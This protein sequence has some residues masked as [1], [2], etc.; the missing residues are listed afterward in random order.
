[1]KQKLDVKQRY[2]IRN[3]QGLLLFAQ[4]ILIKVGIV[5]Q[6][7]LLLT[8]IINGVNVYM[9]ISNIS[10]IIAHLVVMLYCYVG[11]KKSRIFYYI[12]VGFFL[13]AIFINICM[14]FRDIPQIALL[15]SLF[16]LMSVFMFKQDDYKFTNVVIALAALI[17]IAFG[18]YSSITANVD[19]LGPN[20]KM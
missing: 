4:L 5:I 7:L 1:M 13:L 9:L 3:A 10:M 11:Y 17:T 6:L 14:P 8:L 15:T 16:G 2:G 12:T 20:N 19:N 18:I